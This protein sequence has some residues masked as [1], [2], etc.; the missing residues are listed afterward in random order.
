MYA[1][2]FSIYAGNANKALAHDICR[3]L[4]TRMGDVEVFQF[5]N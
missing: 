4:K 5:A 3:Y 2:E 1:D